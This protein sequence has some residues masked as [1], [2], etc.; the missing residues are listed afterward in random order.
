GYEPFSFYLGE[1]AFTFGDLPNM[2]NYNLSAI[3]GEPCITAIDNLNE[4][5]N[6][7]R[8]YP[9]PAVDFLHIDKMHG[10]VCVMVCDLLGNRVTSVNILN[11][12]EIIDITGLD[13][14]IYNL[15]LIG[16]G[17]LIAGERFVKLGY[18]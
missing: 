12:T 14:G 18:K 15:V 7:H 8:I 2:P 11:D 13:N 6:D 3:D 4:T 1:D 9:N 17:G 16:K 10:F 5:E